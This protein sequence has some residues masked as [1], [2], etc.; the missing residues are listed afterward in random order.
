MP[1]HKIKFALPTLEIGSAVVAHI[2]AELPDIVCAQYQRTVDS[3]NCVS[4]EACKLQIPTGSFAQ[5]LFRRPRR[6][7][8]QR[9]G[10]TALGAKRRTITNLFSAHRSIRPDACAAR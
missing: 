3:D 4:F 10:V 7:A 2:G 9:E 1:N 8:G 5:N 6:A